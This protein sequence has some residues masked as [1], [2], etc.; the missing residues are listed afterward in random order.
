[1]HSSGGCARFR[2]FLL[3]P[4]VGQPLLKSRFGSVPSA[5]KRYCLPLFEFLLCRCERVLGVDTRLLKPRF[6]SRSS[7]LGGGL[8]L[9]GT[10][11]AGL[12]F[13]NRFRIRILE[14]L[15]LRLRFLSGCVFGLGANFGFA[16]CG[17]LC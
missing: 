13:R 7:L 2:F 17:R 14:L 3:P 10:L 4:S 6:Q 5:L 16:G 9:L 15:D 12:L 8:F 1:L 11:D